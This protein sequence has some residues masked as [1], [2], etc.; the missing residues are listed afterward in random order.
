[1]APARGLWRDVMIFALPNEA[2]IKIHDAP[3]LILA[4]RRALMALSRDLNGQVTR[5]FSGHEDNGGPAASGRHE[6]IF[7]V[8]D[9]SDQD[10]RI[11]RII[12]AAPWTCD[13]SMQ[14][15]RAVRKNFD[16]VV[17]RLTTV[18]T[19]RLG[20][21]A[22]EQPRSPNDNDPLVGPA[23]VWETRTPYRATRH[24]GR[25]KD[26][27]AAL[28]GD[29]IA[30]CTR[31]HLPR[32][33]VKLLEFSALPSGGGLAARMRLHFATAIQGPLLLGRDSH[34]GGGLFSV[35]RK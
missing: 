21:I 4:V 11:D 17:S 33:K 18:R 1:M 20:A 31:R 13:R 5:L 19:G 2:N 24:A 26:P 16:E 9:D 32:P 22:L 25:R 12:I 15:G 7:L 6:H 30:E 23:C 3:A 28:V 29:V 8:V 35:C 14:P 27:A 34:K 10:G